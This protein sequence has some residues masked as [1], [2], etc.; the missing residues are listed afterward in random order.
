MTKSAF[1]RAHNITNSSVLNGWIKKYQNEIN[2]VS[3]LSEETPN[4]TDIMANLSKEEFKNENA[5]L[6]QRIKELEKALAF[7]RL[8]TEA[9]DL[10]IDIAEKNFN[11]PIRKKAGAKQ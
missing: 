10:M 5:Q 7:S 6:K 11:I 8:E 4:S 1:C 2:P 3:L 9:R